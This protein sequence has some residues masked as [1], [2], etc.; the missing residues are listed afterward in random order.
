MGLALSVGIL[1]DLRENDAEGYEMFRD[2]F[3]QVNQALEHEGL[4]AHNE[5]NEVAR[6][7]RVSFEMFGYSGLHYLRRIAAH[8]HYTGLLPP[9]GNNGAGDDPLLQNYCRDANVQWEQGLTRLVRS[10]ERLQRNRALKVPP[11]KFDHLIDHSDC[12]SFCLPIRFTRIFAAQ[13]GEQKQ[14]QQI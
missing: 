12:E 6:E 2:Y 3:R 1:E 14:W 11:R 5:P 9:P 10:F 7:H 8:K 13:L 4:P